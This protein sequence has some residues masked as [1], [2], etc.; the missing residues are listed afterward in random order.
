MGNLYSTYTG[1]DAIASMSDQIDSNTIYTSLASKINVGKTIVFCATI[2]GNW[3]IGNK[4]NCNIEINAL[5]DKRETVKNILDSIIQRMN[6]TYHPVTFSVFKIDSDSFN[7]YDAWFAEYDY[8]ELCNKSIT[9]FDETAVKDKGLKIEIMVH[10]KYSVTSKSISCKYMLSNYSDDA[11]NCPIYNA[12]KNK[13]EFTTSNL[14]HYNEYT[15]FKDEYCDKPECKLNENCKSFKNIENGSQDIKDLSHMR[16]YKHPPRGSH[17]KLSQNINSLIFNK[18]NDQNT[19]VYEPTTD[20][21]KKYNYNEQDGYLLAL[22]DEVILNGCK[23]DLRP[24]NDKYCILECVDEKMQ[25]KQH[26]LRGSPL[27]KG[28]MLSLVLYTDENN[29]NYDLC[30]SQRNGDFRKWKWFDYCLYKAIYKLSSSEDGAFDVY[31]GLTNVQLNKKSVQCG[32]FTTYTSTSWNKTVAKKFMGDK[33]MII[34]IDTSYKNSYRVKCCNVSWISPFPDECEILFSRHENSVFN[35]GFNC[36][37]LDQND[38]IQTVV[39]SKKS[40]K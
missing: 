22:I 20:D 25:S 38:G 29:C 24:S 36:E 18:I 16:L 13:N 7:E 15:H 9:D 2:I 4:F 27:D 21:E 40:I 14:K 17:I 34:K 39:L 31:S 30:K 23:D 6:K 33:G 28:Q 1:N 12:M 32:Y 19:K 11:M 37:V 5:C 8:E 10:H 35:R 3:K 26:K